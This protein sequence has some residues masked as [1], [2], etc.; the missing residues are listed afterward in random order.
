MSRKGFTIVEMLLYIG[1]FSTI[2]LVTTQILIS[3]TDMYLESSATSSLENNATYLSQK[4]Q[5]DLLRST[6]IVEPANPTITGNRLVLQ[7][8][9]S[10]FVY[11]IQ[12]QGLFLTAEDE[13]NQISTN[14][15]EVESLV[16][17][18]VG[19][20]TATDSARLDLT[21]QSKYTEADG[22]QRTKSYFIVGTPR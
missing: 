19:N 14:D 5:Y 20:G 4:L 8:N 16:V 11:E 1:L 13:T 21:L 22:R 7:I 17:K 9:G 15:V 10:D 6:R 18:R 2:L 3:I 12:N